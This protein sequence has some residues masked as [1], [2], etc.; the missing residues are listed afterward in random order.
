[1]RIVNP[2]F[3]NSAEGG[4]TLA[5]APV[6]WRTDPIALFSNSKPNARELL[7]GIREK[8]GALRDV[9]NVGHV[10]KDGV[11]QPAPGNVIEQIAGSYRAALVAIAD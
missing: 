2:T 9:G 3:G 7:E 8:L 4:E 5:G 6:D 1:M 10:Y 11:G